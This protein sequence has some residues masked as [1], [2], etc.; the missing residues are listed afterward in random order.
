MYGGN[1][2]PTPADHY[3]MTCEEIRT[4]LSALL[5]DEEPGLP[6]AVVSDH[7]THC[8]H[9]RAWQKSAHGLAG[10]TRQLAAG[11]TPDLTAG[12]LSAGLARRRPAPRPGGV[13]RIALA[14]VAV[15]QLLLAVPDLLGAST[16]QLHHS[17][18]LAAIAV[19]VAVGF[20]AAA[21]RPA[22]ALGQ[23]PVVGTFGAGLV[24]TALTDLAAR[25]TF[26][27]A[28]SGH[29]VTVAGLLLL[30]RVA[31]ASG[32]RTPLGLPA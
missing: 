23:L 30:W 18:E 26:A 20:G 11:A 22:L 25:H 24:L 28:E 15:G 16:G 31:V 19:A 6:L 12:V 7:L 29:L 32:R 5:D 21:A 17:H 4:A 27:L 13:A 14:F 8:P 1:R 2:E 3:G 10:E 9:C